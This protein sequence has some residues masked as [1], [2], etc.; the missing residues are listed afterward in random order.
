M[1]AR[2]YLSSLWRASASAV[3][4]SSSANWKPKSCCCASHAAR[5]RSRESIPCSAPLRVPRAF[6]GFSVAA[7]PQGSPRH[8]P[9]WHRL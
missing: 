9:A 8:S 2:R 1:Q 3:S 6:V 7:S 5:P 4:P